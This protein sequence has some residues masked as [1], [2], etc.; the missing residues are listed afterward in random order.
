MVTVLECHRIAKAAEIS[1]L[2]YRP[3]VQA[4]P[5]CNEYTQELAEL[6]RAFQQATN[7]ERRL[8]FLQGEQGTGK[9]ALLDT[10]LAKIHHPGLSVLRARCVQMRG[11]VEPFLP[12]PEALE[13]R[14]REPYGRLLIEHLSHL[15][16][17]WLYQLLNVLDS[18]EIAMLLPKV[19]HITTGP[20]LREGSD[21]FEK[22]C[23][24]SPFILILD[25][26]HWCGAFT[27]D[28]L[29]FLMFVF[30]CEIIDNCQLPALRRWTWCTAN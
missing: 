3:R 7:G 6:Q 9:S 13:R 2:H 26:A 15:A 18:D 21:F 24:N 29:N 28:F 12:L 30:N 14:C 22:L 4:F 10:F 1:I 16:P 23:N 17:T 8:V 11:A 25:N 5:V 20:M 19:S 27:R